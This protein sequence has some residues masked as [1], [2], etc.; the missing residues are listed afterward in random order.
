V[1]GLLV[2]SSITLLQEVALPTTR[3]TPKTLHLDDL[4]TIHP[5]PAGM[6]I[7]ADQIVVAVPLDHDPEPLPVLGTL[8]IAN[9]AAHSL[10]LHKALQQMNLQLER[11]L[12]EI[13]GV[14][15]QAS[16][17]A[18]VEGE[19]TPVAVAQ[20]R[21]PACKSSEETLAKALS[22]SWKDELLFVLRQALVLYEVY[23]AQIAVCDGEIEQYLQRMEARSGE[24]QARLPELPPA[25]VDSKS[26]TAPSLNARARYARLLR[27]DLVA[28]MGLSSSSVQTIISES[29]SEMSRFPSA[30]HF[31]AWLGL[32]PRNEISGGKVERSRRQTV[33]NRARQ[34]F[35][36][37]AQSVS[38]S[39]SSIGA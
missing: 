32:A 8:L 33:V 11:L 15:G 4:P 5:N 12:S 19:R 25:K 38:R 20:Q 10:Q 31:C 27:V 35:G 17:G 13:L 36:Q 39:G 30:K 6:H 14:T 16:I 23:T 7:R 1:R 2:C 24:P 18:I 34:A 37:A 22:G 9:R 28:V 3:R 26:K 21:N 29:G